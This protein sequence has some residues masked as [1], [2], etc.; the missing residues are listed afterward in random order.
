MSAQQLGDGRSTS[1]VQLL[2]LCSSHLLRLQARFLTLRWKKHLMPSS[3]PSWPPPLASDNF[4]SLTLLA[5]TYTLSHFL[6]YLPVPSSRSS[7][8]SPTSASTSA[9]YA[10]LALNPSPFPPP[11]FWSGLQ[12][13]TDLQR[14]LRA[15][16]ARRW[17]PWPCDGCWGMYRQSGRVYGTVVGYLEGGP[18]T[19][20]PAGLIAVAFGCDCSVNCI[21]RL[22]PLHLG[23]FRSD[24]ILHALEGSVAPMPRKQVEF[25]TVSASF[26]A[27]SQ[28]A[29]VL[30]K[31]F[32]CSYGVDCC[33]SRFFLSSTNYF[34]SSP[35]LEPAN[36]S[37]NHT[38]STIVEGLV[39]AHR[40]YGVPE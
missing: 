27:V 26:G 4:N 15:H 36:L 38:T 16:R 28:H 11:S 9:I 32:L 29:A 3:L 17:L 31:Y 24:Y 33:P 19:R 34:D 37:P 30:H 13:S 39:A 20:V 2:R 23:I 6:L 40:A 22:Q 1:P 5:T 7:E 25:K 18:R 8:A 14:A 10:P 21:A 35:Y 12:A